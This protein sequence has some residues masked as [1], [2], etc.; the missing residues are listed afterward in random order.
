LEKFYIYP[1][2]IRNHQI[3]EES[4]SGSSKVYNVLMQYENARCQPW[5]RCLSP[6]TVTVTGTPQLSAEKHRSNTAL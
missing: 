2:T 1:E 6:E 5:L 3:D 4:T